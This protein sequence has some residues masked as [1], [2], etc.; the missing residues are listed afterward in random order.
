[1]IL[2]ATTSITSLPPWPPR[3]PAPLQNLLRRLSHA[4][5]EGFKGKNYLRRATT[6]LE[7]RYFGNALI[8]SETEKR[9]LLNHHLFPSPLPPPGEATAPYYRRSR[10][11]DDLSRMQHLDFF[12]WLPGDILAKA[13][14]MAAPPPWSSVSPS[15]ITAWWRWRARSAPLVRGKD[16]K[17]ILREA[18]TAYLLPRTAF[19]PQVRFPHP[20][21][22]LDSPPFYHRLQELFTSPTAAHFSTPYLL[23][24]L[25]ATGRAGLPDRRLGL[26]PSFSSGIV[27]TWNRE[28]FD[29]DKNERI[30]P[31]NDPVR[32]RRPH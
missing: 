29:W 1:M 5:P 27:F 6:P 8:F 12:T 16:T 9:R 2:P 14:R 17:Y 21:R 23:E 31:R 3:L 10:F 19:S 32:P 26:S 15:S 20:H 24:M 13:D 18:A 25:P 22:P 30:F 4:L 11:L 28:N 7:Q